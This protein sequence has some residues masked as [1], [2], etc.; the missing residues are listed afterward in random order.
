MIACASAHTRI[1]NRCKVPTALIWRTNEEKKHTKRKKQIHTRKRI[2]TLPRTARFWCY[3][4]F[5]WWKIVT[6][7]T[8]KR[9]NFTPFSNRCFAWSR[10]LCLN[11]GDGGDGGRFW[12]SGTGSVYIVQPSKYKEQQQQ[13]Q[14]IPNAILPTFISVLNVTCIYASCHLC[15]QQSR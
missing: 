8:M 5:K 13:R 15:R 7:A 14:T 10:V 4:C 1:E 11:D 3:T 9:D 2:K 6:E 12:R